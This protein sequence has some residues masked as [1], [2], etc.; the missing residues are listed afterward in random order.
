MTNIPTQPIPVDIWSD[1]VSPYCFLAALRLDKLAK[2]EHIAPII[3]VALLV[4]PH[5]A[6]HITDEKRAEAER[7]RAEAAGIL[8]SEF[9][10]E[11]N[12]GPIGIDTYDAHLLMA[13]A[14]RAGKGPALLME[15]MRAYW[16][17]AKSIDDREVI[18]EAAM[19]AGLDP[20]EVDY[21][22]EDPNNTD[23]VNRGMEIGVGHGIRSVPSF[24]FASKY[25][26]TGSA[27]YADLEDM[28]NKL[29]EESR[30]AG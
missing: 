1:F 30:K 8:R 13:H 16:L 25:L 2:Q 20:K 22:W 6:P 3:W 28:T 11:M 19:A 15:L 5:G 27:E 12:P 26:M 14:T 21:A 18:K 7:E 23:H 9:R 10:L 24:I 29:K 17:E 4:R